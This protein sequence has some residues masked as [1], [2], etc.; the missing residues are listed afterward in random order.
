MENG[1]S[2]GGHWLESNSTE[3]DLIRYY[4]TSS[5]ENIGNIEKLSVWKIENHELIYKF[6]K[7]SSG[8]L[9]LHGW[10][11]A[12][13]LTGENN[14]EQLCLKGFSFEALPKAGMEFNVGSVR[15]GDNKNQPDEFCFLF[16]DIAV[17]R[18]KIFEG[19]VEIPDG[20]DSLYFPPHVVDRTKEGNVVLKDYKTAAQVDQRPSRYVFTSY[21]WL[22]SPMS[23][24]VF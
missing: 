4:L 7:R 23:N 20:Y 15:L 19:S 1:K 18:S 2:V 24:C 21:L 14:L 3:Y 13:D 16:Y 11:K 12:D 10:L 6:E 5:T 8:M 22:L 17:G 9:R